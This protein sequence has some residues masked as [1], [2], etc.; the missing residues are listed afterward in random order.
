[1]N[2]KSS[3]SWLAITAVLV[4]LL[5]SIA[6]YVNT[7]LPAYIDSPSDSSSEDTKPVLPE[8][9]QYLTDSV[10]FDYPAAWTQTQKGT[11]PLF[12]DSDGTYLL[13]QKSAYRP[14]INAVTEASVSNELAASN[15]I[16]LY[17]ER[18]SSS[19]FLISYCADDITTWEYVIWDREQEYHLIFSTGKERTD[20]VEALI[21]HIFDSFQ[22]EQALPIPENMYLVYNSFGNFEFAVPA[23][24]DSGMSSEAFSATHMETGAAYSVTVSETSLT[25]LQDISQL[26]YVQKAAKSRSNLYIKSYGAAASQITAESIYTLD[27]VQMVFYHVLSL[28]N[29][30]LYESMLDV[31][32][33][34]GGADY[35]LVMG[36]LKYFR[37]FD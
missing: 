2:L 12:L 25:S 1:M 11:N 6:S 26:Q 37:T 28:H 8:M 29:G 21:S 19:S 13:L 5:C 36:C 18:L 22:W 32:V 14:Q 9:S 23:D 16:P 10:T 4:V 24:W 33:S 3:K 35:Q 7:A 20:T 31:P 15:F 27:G 30:Y 34:S 17:Y